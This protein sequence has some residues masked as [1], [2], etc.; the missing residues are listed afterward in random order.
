[1]NTCRQLLLA[2]G[3]AA[4]LVAFSGPLGAADA[5]QPVAALTLAGDHAGALAAVERALKV[6]PEAAHAAGFSYL[7]GRLLDRLGRSSEAADAYA[8]ALGK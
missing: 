2:G 1:M 3:G 7:R 4:W 6:D 8:E 5:R